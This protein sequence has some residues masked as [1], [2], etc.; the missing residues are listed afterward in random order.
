VDYDN[1]FNHEEYYPDYTS[2]PAF[3][4]CKDSLNQFFKR[5]HTPYCLTQLE[6][7]FEKQYSHWITYGAIK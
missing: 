3:I 6:V 7:L 5:K 2:D 4:A 1:Y